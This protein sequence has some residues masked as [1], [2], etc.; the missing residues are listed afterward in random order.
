M[1]VAATQ[2][3]G[4]D[5]FRGQAGWCRHKSE[6]VTFADFEIQTITA[7]RQINSG[8]RLRSGRYE[9]I[10]LC[11]SGFQRGKHKTRVAFRIDLQRNRLA[12]SVAQRVRVA[13]EFRR[14]RKRNYSF[15]PIVLACGNRDVSLSFCSAQ[16]AA[17][18]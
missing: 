14:E 2:K 16:L 17:R 11:L 12:V 9:S 18:Q 4:L 3:D 13:F 7:A 6:Y 8:L 5:V 10:F 1:N 15:V